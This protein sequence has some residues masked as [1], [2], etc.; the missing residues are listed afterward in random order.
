MLPGWFQAWH[1][2]QQLWNV[3]QYDLEY[4]K[5]NKDMSSSSK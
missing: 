5:S 3:I 1:H 2:E 4:S